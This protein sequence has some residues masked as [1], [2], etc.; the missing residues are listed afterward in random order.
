VVFEEHLSVK[1]FG[2]LAVLFAETVAANAAAPTATASRQLSSQMFLSKS[3][4]A[5]ASVHSMTELNAEP[6]GRLDR[7]LQHRHW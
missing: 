1:E 6:V 4:L 5:R 3:R 7:H 2:T